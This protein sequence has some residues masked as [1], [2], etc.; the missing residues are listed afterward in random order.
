[1]WPSTFSG[2][3]W[4]LQWHQW[5][6]RWQTREWQRWHRRQC[7][8]VTKHIGPEGFFCQKQ[9]TSCFFCLQ[10]KTS[11]PMWKEISPAPTSALPLGWNLVNRK[12]CFRQ[13]GM[14][15]T[16]KKVVNPIINFHDLNLGVW[17]RENLCLSTGTVLFLF[18]YWLECLINSP[19]LFDNRW[20]LKPMGCWCFGVEW[21]DVYCCYWK[22][23]Q[24]KKE[25]IK[26]RKCSHWYF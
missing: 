8:M 25:W 14:F 7:K 5:W 22:T 17:P 13:T 6:Q 26:K 2:W 9:K 19:R 15:L 1:M 4:Q 21:L 24:R 10:K 23:S 11:G 12:A 20:I 16:N 18:K 3:H